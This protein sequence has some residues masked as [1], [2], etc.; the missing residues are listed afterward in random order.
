MIEGILLINFDP[1][2]VS[3][4]QAPQSSSNT[5]SRINVWRDCSLDEIRDLLI[6]LGAIF[7]EESWPPQECIL[8]L[9]VAWPK[10]KLSLL[11]PQALLEPFPIIDEPALRRIQIAVAAAYTAAAKI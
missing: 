10:A 5:E 7:P 8:R 6:S 9:P 1:P 2:Y 3:F 11:N 4:S